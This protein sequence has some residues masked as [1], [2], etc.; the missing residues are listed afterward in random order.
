MYPPLN[1]CRT[2][3][4]RDACTYPTSWLLLLT[5][6]LHVYPYVSYCEPCIT[7]VLY[8]TLTDQLDSFPVFAAYAYCQEVADHVALPLHNW[9]GVR[10][11]PIYNSSSGWRAGMCL[12]YTGGADQ[13]YTG[14]PMPQCSWVVRDAGR[15]VLREKG[16]RAFTSSARTRLSFWVGRWRIQITHVSITFVFFEHKYRNNIEK[17]CKT[18]LFCAISPCWV[19][20]ACPLPRASRT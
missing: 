6:E 18:S 8:W 15:S 2:A 7:V 13:K 11:V 3:D 12:C 19:L 20:S 4:L 14:V 9:D 17:S 10:R 1:L 5:L 16:R